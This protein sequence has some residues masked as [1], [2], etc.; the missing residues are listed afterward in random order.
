MGQELIYTSAPRGLKAGSHGFCTVI[1]TAGMNANLAQRLESLS[2]YRHVFGPQDTNARLNPVVFSHLLLVMGGRPYHVLSRIADAGLDYTHRTNKLAHHVVLDVSERVSA[3]PAWLLGQSGFL[4][5]TFDGQPRMLPVGRRPPEGSETLGACRHWA[6]VTGDAGW[7][8]VLAEATALGR[9]AYLIFRPGVEMLPLLAESLA[10]LPPEK[11]WDITFSTYLTGLPPGVECQL[12]C[13]VQG[14]PEH[15]RVRQTP[16][17]LVIDLC[18]S[19]GPAPEGEY[20][21]AARSG[22]VSR[23]AGP[24]APAVDEYPL[25]RNA[26]AFDVA[27]AGDDAVAARSYGLQGGSP[28]PLAQPTYSTAS[29]LDPVL[30]RRTFLRRKEASKWPPYALLAGIVLLFVGGATALWLASRGGTETVHNNGEVVSIIEQQDNSIDKPADE[31]AKPAQESPVPDAE[32]A[33]RSEGDSPRSSPKADREEPTVAGDQTKLQQQ[34]DGP[35]QDTPKSSN[36]PSRQTEGNI[37]QNE[38]ADAPATPGPDEGGKLD[39]SAKPEGTTENS[40]SSQTQEAASMSEGEGKAEESTGTQPPKP[41]KPD[42]PESIEIVSEDGK[43]EQDRWYDIVGPGSLQPSDTLELVG[44]STLLPDFAFHKS[45]P[46]GE[47]RIEERNRGIHIATF[48]S[49]EGNLKFRW[50]NGYIQARLIRNCRLVVRRDETEVASIALRKSIRAD[51]LPSGLFMDSKAIAL[52]HLE[53]LPATNYLK[54]EFVDEAVATPALPTID[55]S[56]LDNGNFMWNVVIRHGNEHINAVI[57]KIEFVNKGD[58][59]VARDPKLTIEISL[60]DP[61]RMKEVNE[62]FTESRAEVRRQMGEMEKKVQ[63]AIQ[64]RQTELQKLNPGTAPKDQQPDRNRKIEEH[65]SKI[66]ELEQPARLLELLDAL[67]KV[68]VGYRIHVDLD[69]GKR[70]LLVEGMGKP[71]NGESDAA[72]APTMDTNLSEDAR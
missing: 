57:R 54:W 69:G 43:L 3:G 33:E 72:Q 51:K 21:H 20:A 53:D 16:N 13:V 52:P 36:T 71:S 8:G 31:A 9:K 5:T 65:K 1:S 12:S 48:E 60:A 61:G 32:A 58:Q 40:V 47:W 19:L 45:S 49:H 26:P 70:C 6:R 55:F 28:P 38:V 2:G 64:G 46:K 62:K 42:W 17:A 25:P 29:Q 22:D 59:I 67:D 30:Q 11:R 24:A 14:S 56:L 18:G 35:A 50:Q 68:H 66:N 63:D 10:L 15:A 39:E 23:L 34:G 27:L 44:L 41:S 7:G 37:A 4:A